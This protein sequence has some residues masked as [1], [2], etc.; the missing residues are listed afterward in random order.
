MEIVTL[1]YNVSYPI[2]AQDMEM[3]RK[4][5]IREEA[6]NLEAMPTELVTTS[7]KGLANKNDMDA[8]KQLVQ[9]IN[10]TKGKI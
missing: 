9:L 6:A 8:Q 7:K 10:E 2:I 4:L 3:M 5:K 1:F